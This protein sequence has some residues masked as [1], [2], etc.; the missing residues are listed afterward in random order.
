MRAVLTRLRSGARRG[1]RSWVALALMIG[2]FNGVVLAAAI[3]ARRTETAYPRFLERTLADDL[4]LSPAMIP[5]ML[6]SRVPPAVA[7]RTE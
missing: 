1:W 3:G 5:G 4:L 2:I 7:L 6:A